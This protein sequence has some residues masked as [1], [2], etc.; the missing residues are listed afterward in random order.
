MILRLVLAAV[1]AACAGVALAKPAPA[2]RGQ[3]R[4]L[5]E[6][7]STGVVY[8]GCFNM[9]QLVLQEVGVSQDTRNVT[10]AGE[11]SFAITNRKPHFGISRYD[12]AW[13]KAYLIT[14]IHGAPH[15]GAQECGTRCQDDDS[16]WCG[17]ANNVTANAVFKVNNACE[18]GAQ[19]VAVYAV[20]AVK[21]R[22]IGII[23]L[24]CCGLALVVIEVIALVIFWWTRPPLRR[25]MVTEKDMRR[26][27][28]EITMTVTGVNS[29][30]RSGSG[31]SSTLSSSTG[32]EESKEGATCSNEMESTKSRNEALAV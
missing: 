28:R 1:C 13:G 32:G 12:S 8:E 15:Y 2:L 24:Y 3:V 29:I 11:L 19:M 27:R 22:K 6:T 26:A 17:C 4:R 30:Q 5:G 21:T 16:R 14:G 23:V 25:R 9:S 31:G 10:F 7:N 20:P 18:I